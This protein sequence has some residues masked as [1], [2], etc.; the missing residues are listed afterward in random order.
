MSGFYAALTGELVRSAQNLF[1][2]ENWDEERFG[3]YRND[4]IASLLAAFNAVLR[5]AGLALVLASD[6]SSKTTALL[7]DF[8]E[9]LSFLYDRLEDEESKE[10]LTKLIAYRILGHRRVKLPLSTKEY[11]RTRRSVMS[12]IEGREVLPIKFSKWNLQIFDLSPLGYP[13]RLFT[14]PLGVV[15]LFLVKHYSY[16]TASHRIEAEEGEYVI[17][18]GGCWGDTSLFFA[19]AVGPRGRVYTFE[20][21]PE[22]LAVMRK[23]LALNPELSQRIEI[24][25][26][27]LW[28]TPNRTVSILEDGPAT[29]LSE[30]TE[31]PNGYLTSTIDDCVSRGQIPRVD[32]IK[33]DIEGA[34]LAALQGASETIR[35][36]RPQLA[37]SLYH[38][39]NDFV[40]IP[41][42]LSSLGVKYRLFLS[43]ATIHHEETVLFATAM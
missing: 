15:E 38:S 31:G 10:L 41:R 5:R 36:F 26:R 35:E 7:Q 6:E 4:A 13:F 3:P 27:P 34:E 19:D 32:F 39:L 16:V 14:I 43:H 30:D 40:D 18:A 20:F 17:D 37:I 2:S 33:M 24:I 22:N 8:G 12:L 28:H 1:G 29:R 42:F 25:C 23:N 21:F 11:W 9:G